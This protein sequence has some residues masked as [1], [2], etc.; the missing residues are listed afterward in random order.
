M[1]YRINSDIV[2]MRKI[3][4]VLRLNPNFATRLIRQQG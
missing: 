3:S 2:L 1:D 4:K